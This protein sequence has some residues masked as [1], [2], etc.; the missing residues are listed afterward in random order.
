MSDD[1]E[2]G[3]V[4]GD[5]PGDDDR[6]ELTN[7]RFVDVINGCHLESGTSLVV[8]SGRIRSLP[9]ASGQ[10]GDTKPDFTV[11]LKGKT[12]LPGLFNTHCHLEMAVPT[13]VP[14]VREWRAMKRYHQQQVAK[15]LAECLS[16]GVTNVR[17]AWSSDLRPLRTLKERISKGELPGPRIIL[18]VS[19]GPPGGYQTPENTVGRRLTSALLG[20]PQTDYERADFGV[21][22]FP[23]DANE[24]QVRDA[25]DRA[26]DERGAEAI[27]IGE[28]LE[29]TRNLKPDAT[30][31][32]LDQLEAVVDQARRRGLQSTMHCVSV[33][34]FR[35]GVESGIS[36]L[37]HAPFDAPLTQADIDA[38][39]ASDTVIEPT[40]TVAYCCCWRIPGDP[41][42]DDAEMIRLSRFRERTLAGL[43]DRHWV[44]ELRDCAIRGHDK[45]NSGRFRALG[46]MNMKK[47]LMYYSGAVRHGASNVI[48]LFR[49]GACM[50]AGND[51]GVPP[52]TP[53]MI[54]HEIAMFDFTLNADS[55]EVRFTGADALR[56][57]TIHSAR[58]L[59]L[60]RD[61][62]SIEV[63]KI[64]DLAVLDGD[65]LQDSSLIGAPVAAL[66]MDGRLAINRCGLQFESARR[67]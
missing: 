34:S 30:I 45:I 50:A 29:N 57:A 19:I 48:E 3:F 55:A 6:V 65:P 17:D 63:G 13:L 21:V 44:S 40:C 62:G 66:F 67:P 58:S 12:V 51:G 24:S 60:D 54:G 10:L 39:N 38:F 18:S 61:F 25:V 36:S 32:S 42:F 15:D 1:P 49:Q 22:V 23:V 8:E 7:G 20:M 35:R 4:W 46:L 43:M 53:A 41:L 31:M 11:D 64:A 9:G 56:T 14:S 37:A 28:Q 33:A 16:R 47:M 5:Q 26:V 2:V 27:K 59:G 52:C